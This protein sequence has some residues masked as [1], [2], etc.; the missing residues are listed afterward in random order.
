MRMTPLLIFSVRENLTD[1]KE[2]QI[3]DSP[4]F[5]LEFRSL[6]RP[7]KIRKL[8]SEEDIM[9]VEVREESASS[10]SDKLSQLFKLLSPQMIQSA[11]AWLTL[12]QEF[13]KSPSLK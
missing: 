2:T 7:R 11:R 13:Q 4:R 10:L 12:P 8:S 9:P 5:S 3:L 6:M 1:P